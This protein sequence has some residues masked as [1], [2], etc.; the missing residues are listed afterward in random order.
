[1]YL[2]KA[3]ILGELREVENQESFY[4]DL[5]FDDDEKKPKDRVEEYLKAGGDGPLLD[6]TSLGQSDWETNTDEEFDEDDD[7]NDD[8]N[9]DEDSD[10]EYDVQCASDVEYDSEE[11]TFH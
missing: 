4:F 8:E 11:N 3:T 7:E 2:T 1:M 6:M 9:D 5:P 10:M